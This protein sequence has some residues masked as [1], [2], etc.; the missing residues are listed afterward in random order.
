MRSIKRQTILLNLITTRYI[1]IYIYIL[2]PPTFYN[3]K[4]T[5]SYF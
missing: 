4:L 2:P 3:S 5:S 1:Y